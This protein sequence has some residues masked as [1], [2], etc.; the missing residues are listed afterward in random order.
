MK[1][2]AS[3]LAE[4]PLFRRIRPSIG[5]G[6][7]GGGSPPRMGSHAPEGLLCKASG[8]RRADFCAEQRRKSNGIFPVYASARTSPAIRSPSSAPR[9]KST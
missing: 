1:C 2:Q 8:K 4:K 3:Q 7:Q 5:G 6:A 9:P